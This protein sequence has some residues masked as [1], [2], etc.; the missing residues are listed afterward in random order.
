LITLFADL[1]GQIWPHAR[2]GGQLRRFAG[3]A[4]WLVL[5]LAVVAVIGNTPRAAR[6]YADRRLAEHACRPAITDLQ[7]EAQWPSRHIASDQIEIWRDLYPWLRSAYSFYI[8]D[9]YDPTDQPWETMVAERLDQQ[10]GSKEFWWIVDPARP[11]RAQAYF[12][13]PGVQ[14]LE[15]RTWGACQGRRVL[16][17]AQPPLAVATVNGGPLQLQ[18]L[19]LEKAKV[20]ADLHLVLYWQADA[21]VTSSYTVFVQ[22]LDGAGQVVAQQDNLPVTGLAPTDTW[23]PGKLIRDPYRLVL[24]ATIQSGSYQLQIGLYTPEG[25]VMLTMPDNTQSDHLAYEVEVQ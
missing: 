15:A 2:R 9:G 25:R 13:L 23:Q 3:A 6:A 4:T 14:V 24:P 7:A 1:L 21:P 17:A 5:S 20:G 12:A 19:A 8:V 16:R 10:M 22:L 11:S 18:T